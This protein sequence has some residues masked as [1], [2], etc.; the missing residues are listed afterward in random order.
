MG[1]ILYYSDNKSNR[2]EKVLNRRFCIEFWLFL[3]Y[4]IIK[5]KCNSLVGAEYQK[6][7]ANAAMGLCLNR[8]NHDYLYE[9]DRMA[10]LMGNGALALIDARSGFGDLFNE[11]EIAF[12]R[13]EDELYRKIDYFRKNPEDR[14][15]V[16]EK[17]WKKYH[18][19]F[20]ERLIAQYITDLMFD[21]FD[22]KN[23]PWPT[24]AE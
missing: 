2:N 22:A 24:L 10:H 14:M 11:D 5:D 23:Y 16:A 21:E 9:S 15:A 20:N 6:T 4:V 19:L 7:F 8:S 17:G 3:T 18:E 13:D 1:D 12:Y